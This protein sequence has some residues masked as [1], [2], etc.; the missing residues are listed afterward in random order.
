MRR[1]IRWKNTSWIIQSKDPDEDILSGP[2]KVHTLTLSKPTQ[3]GGWGGVLVGV[4]LYYAGGRIFCGGGLIFCPLERLKTTTE[5]EAIPPTTLTWDPQLWIFW[6]ST[7][8]G[9]VAMQS[10]TRGDSWG[11]GETFLDFPTRLL[12]ILRISALCSTVEC[13]P[14][15]GENIWPWK[16]KVEYRRRF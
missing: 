5:S 7:L 6:Q 3:G 14:S 11:C 12:R 9:T 4:G 13:H 16:L 1:K 8:L 2:F 15:R 10:W